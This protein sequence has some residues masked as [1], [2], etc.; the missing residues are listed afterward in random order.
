[1]RKSHIEEHGEIRVRS[2]EQNPSF[3]TFKTSVNDAKTYKKK[4]VIQ[5]TVTHSGSLL[6]HTIVRE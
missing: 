3:Y 1:M 2:I 6:T 5:A 4:E